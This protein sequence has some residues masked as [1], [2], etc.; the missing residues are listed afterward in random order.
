MEVQIAQLI[1]HCFIDGMYPDTSNLPVVFAASQYPGR[2][3]HLD[4]AED[5][6]LKS[7]V[8]LQDKQSPSLEQVQQ[9]YG[10]D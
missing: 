9:S 3:Q 5:K 2:G 10:Q 7:T 8:A 4:V 1:G 6:I